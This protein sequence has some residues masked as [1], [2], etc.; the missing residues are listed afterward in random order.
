MHHSL[1]L[2][3]YNTPLKDHV[4]VGAGTPPALHVNSISSSRED[5]SFVG[6]SMK[7]GMAGRNTMH[8]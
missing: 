3:S 4:T 5:T 1:F 8:L 2:R 7:K 6:S